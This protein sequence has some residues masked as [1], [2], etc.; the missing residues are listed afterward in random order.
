[1]NIQTKKPIVPPPPTFGSLDKG[2]AFECCGD[3]YIK[4]D[5]EQLVGHTE[6]DDTRKLNAC[7]LTGWRKGYRCYLPEEELVRKLGN[8]IEE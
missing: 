4:L 1:M 8:L 3:S 7:G 6:F 5:P 2:D